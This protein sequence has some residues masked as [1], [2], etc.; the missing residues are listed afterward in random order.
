MSSEKLPRAQ[1]DI[2]LEAYERAYYAFQYTQEQCERTLQFVAQAMK[3][4]RGEAPIESLNRLMVPFKPEP[5]GIDGEATRGGMEYEFD[6]RF[7]ND[8]IRIYVLG[9]TDPSRPGEVEPYHLQVRFSPPMFIQRER[10]ESLLEL[11]VVPGWTVDGGNLRPPGFNIHTGRPSNGGNFV[12]AP[13]QQPTGPYNI[14]V[15]LNYLVDE[16]RNPYTTR[17]LITLQ[18]TRRYLTPEQLKQRDAK[19]LGSLPYTGDICTAAGKYM[20]VLL[21]DPNN[22]LAHRHWQTSA[23]DAGDRFP[24]C[25]YLNP[26]TDQFERIPVWWR[27]VAPD[28]WVEQRGKHRGNQPSA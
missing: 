11:K 14:E 1:I 21:H 28:P 27:W 12:Y 20:P 2:D 15:Q 16:S 23:I 3:V 7:M 9:T 17:E 8:W 24:Q 26:R 18:I 4:L 5:R 22:C 13:L 25:S 6:T 19:R 10:L